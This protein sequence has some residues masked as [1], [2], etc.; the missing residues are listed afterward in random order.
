MNCNNCMYRQNQYCRRDLPFGVMHITPPQTKCKFG[1]PRKAK[2]EIKI[3]P[4]ERK[5]KRVFVCK[6]EEK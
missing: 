1:K 5:Y 4:E 6:K 3:T 2:V